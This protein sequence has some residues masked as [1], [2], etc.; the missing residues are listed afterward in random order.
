VAGEYLEN[1]LWIN[2]FFSGIEY[3]D[4]LQVHFEVTSG[5]GSVDSPHQTLS[6]SPSASYQA[7]ST[8]WK[9]G[10][11][12]QEQTVTAH[13][14]GK[15][16]KLLTSLNFYASVNFY[17]AISGNGQ[18][19]RIGEYLDDELSITFNTDE[20]IQVR[21]EVTSGGGSID[22]PEQTISPQN[23]V[24]STKWKTG[25]FINQT[26]TASMYDQGGRHLTDIYF[27]STT[28]SKGN[29]DLIGNIPVSF[30]TMAKDMVNGK[31]YII[32]NGRLHIKDDFYFDQWNIVASFQD[33]RCT[34]I[35]VDSKGIL[36][37]A[38]SDGD[39][40]RSADQGGSFV[41]C[42]R[43][44]PETNINSLLLNITNN[45]YIWAN[46]NFSSVDGETVY[47]S[48]RYSTDRGQTWVSTNYKTY[49]TLGNIY[50]FSDNSFMAVDINNDL[51]LNQSINGTYWSKSSK[52]L[53]NNVMG[54]L[55]T[56]KDEIILY[57]Q[58][59]ASI[60][61]YKST[62]FLTTFSQ[63]CSVPIN[64]PS[65]RN[66]VEKYKDS[67]YFCFP[68]GGIFRTKD[69]ETFDIVWNNESV[70]NLM[71][72]HNGVLWIFASEP[73]FSIY[74]WKEKV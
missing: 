73:S 65:T 56:E 10:F 8:K 14:Y 34:S 58:V 35:K 9:T 33:K 13:I 4:E 17:H 15:N 69:F 62:D 45:D 2:Y 48:W 5:G 11:L 7:V 16:R 27:F 29:W 49:S 50:S 28:D 36:Y 60:V 61:I 40:Y 18:T 44:F 74:C 47:T 12:S 63:V 32:E 72:D 23:P 43:P 6:A 1:E 70:S 41:Q 46:N 31:T 22:T 30:I 55:V 64:W 68:G 71:I 54:M 26:V 42:A 53:P 21:F 37:V 39:L 51:I 38:T 25:N 3:L 57:G 67:Y 52:K 59:D 66:F 24:V 19:G 20:T